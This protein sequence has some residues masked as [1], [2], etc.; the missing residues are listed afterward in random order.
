MDSSGPELSRPAAEPAAAAPPAAPGPPA[1]ED[2]RVEELLRVNTRLAAEVRSLSTGRS[3]APR[4]DSMPASRRL[5]RLIAERDAIEAHFQ[6]AL[7]GQR[8]QRGAIEQ[9][10]THVAQL[11]ADNAEL[12]ATVAHLRSGPRGAARR[13]FARIA[14]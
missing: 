12:A 7:A 14:R 9:L 2:R 6:E 1:D 8:E 13:L 4:Q 5:A 3:Q 11:E 10:R